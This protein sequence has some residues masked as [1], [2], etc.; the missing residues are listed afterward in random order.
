MAK[1][2]ETRI[3]V[4]A[5]VLLAL[6]LGA[7]YCHNVTKN[8]VHTPVVTAVPALDVE[9]LDAPAPIIFNGCFKPLI[10]GKGKG[11]VTC[12]AVTPPVIA[13]VPLPAP[14]EPYAPPAAVEMPAPAYYAPDPAVTPMPAPAPIV[15]LGGSSGGGGGYVPREL[16]HTGG[17]FFDRLPP[18]F[19]SEEGREKCGGRD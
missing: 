3:V 6:E 15:V 2:T 12:G 5:A 7:I 16:P 10:A 13:A 8:A 9:L 18:C 17:G 19:P 4:A 14:V 11:K 1:I